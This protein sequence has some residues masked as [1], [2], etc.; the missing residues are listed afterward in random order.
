M[1]LTYTFGVDSVMA[2]GSGIENEIGKGFAW[3]A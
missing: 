1:T 3:S 2:G